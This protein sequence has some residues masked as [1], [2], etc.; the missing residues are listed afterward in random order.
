MSAEHAEL[1]LSLLADGHSVTK[2]DSGDSMLPSITSGAVLQIEPLAQTQPRL[3]DV[4][5]FE[6]CDGRTIIHRVSLCFRRKSHLWI[7][8]WGDNCQKPDA[9]VPISKVLGR[10]ASMQI[11]GDWKPLRNNRILYFHYFIKRYGWF[12]LGKTLE[13]MKRILTGRSSSSRPIVSG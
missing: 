3:G 2:K 9:P 5:F 12:Y 1:V 4:V 11:N 10:I 13:K 6:A 8:T 7:Q